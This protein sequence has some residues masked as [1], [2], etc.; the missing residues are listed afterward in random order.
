MVKPRDNIRVGGK[1]NSILLA[2]SKCTV[3]WADMCERITVKA[4]ERLQLAGIRNSFA[5]FPID[6]VVSQLMSP[7]GEADSMITLGILGGDDIVGLTGLTGDAPSPVT[8]IVDMGG[9][10]L[11]IPTA[12]ARELLAVHEE[13]RELV[14]AYANLAQTES[15]QWLAASLQMAVIQRVAAYLLLMHDVS[16]ETVL[17]VTHIVMSKRMAI[18][19]PSITEAVKTMDVDG[20]ALVRQTDRGRIDIKN[21]EGLRALVQE[22]WPLYGTHRQAFKNMASPPEA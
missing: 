3:Q 2:L 22:A 7:N 11:R 10:V 19:R 9:S 15:W 4:G 20:M 6:A 5:Y 1:T 14:Q 21:V 18:R 16:G 12:M 8:A 17:P 13:S